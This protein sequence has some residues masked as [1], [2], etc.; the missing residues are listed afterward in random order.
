M[1]LPGRMPPM[2]AALLVTVAFVAACGDDEATAPAARCQTVSL[3]VS[4]SAA[5]PVITDVG[6][7]VQP[8][9][10]VVVATVTDPQGTSNL[11]GVE[12]SIGVFSDAL[13]GGSP[14]DV[15]DDIAES[16]IE[17][18]FGTVVD[19]AVNPDLHGAISA[20]QAWPVEVDMSD[21]D[22]NRT[23][24]RVLARIIP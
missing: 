10:I 9:G 22:G 8:S 11:L 19:A 6:L 4:G 18:T 1:N 5:A 7:E 20:A 3:P 15:R 12:Q 23:N 21:L 24:A 16:G 2:L 17:E 13:C 14:I